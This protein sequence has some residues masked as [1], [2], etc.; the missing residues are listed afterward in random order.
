MESGGL[1][2]TNPSA[3]QNA[4]IAE[5]AGYGHNGLIT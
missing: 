2:T 4:V 3:A 5:V 1:T